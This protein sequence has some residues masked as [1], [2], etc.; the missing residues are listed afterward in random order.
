MDSIRY[1]AGRVT[2]I[3]CET[4]EDERGALSPID[5]DL[6]DFKPVR[7]FLVTA[8]PG[9]I[10]GAHGHIRARQLLLRVGGQIEVELVYAG[11]LERLTLD[12]RQ[13]AVLI[14]PPV[15]S[16]QIYR[17]DNAALVV[18]CDTPYDPDDYFL[19]RN[20]AM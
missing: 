9:S 8:H 17:G 15:W 19:D 18:L 12:S 5:F 6:Y 11:Q 2:P 14:E 1:C 3:V 16:R 4:F 10:R 13:H 20:D 7:A